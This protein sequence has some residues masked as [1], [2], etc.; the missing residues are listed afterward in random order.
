MMNR[1]EAELIA[2]NSLL[3]TAYAIAQRR[4]EDTN[5]EPFTKNVYA[6][7]ERQLPMVNALQAA[8]SAILVTIDGDVVRDLQGNIVG[9]VAKAT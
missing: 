5:W 4:G 1:Y 7:L 8:E 6:A 9:T 2:A 3:R